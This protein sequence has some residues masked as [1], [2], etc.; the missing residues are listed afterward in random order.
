M[1]I[2]CFGAH[3]DDGEVYAGGTCI[4]WAKAGH[5][6]TLVSMT[7]GDV[8]HYGMAGGELAKRRAAECQVAAKRGGYNS[9]VLDNHD[10]E[11]EP[12]LA[13]RKQ[14][15]RLIRELDAD[16]V[17]SHG[18]MDYHPDHRHTS[19]VVQDAAFMVM[20]PN[21]CPHVPALTKN[22]VFL[23]MLNGLSSTYPL[24]PHIAV[25]V[26]AVMDTKFAALD[27]M[28]SQFYE[29]LPWLDGTLETVPKSMAKRREW[30]AET[31]GPV[32]EAPA[33]QFRTVLAKWYGKT[34]ASKVKHAEIFEIS[35]F[36]HQPAAPEIKRLFPFLPKRRA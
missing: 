19:T 35:P 11:L 6:V 10:G 24:K 8:G 3:P 22:P 20:V 7:N 30:L 27:A 4:Q 36:G 12:S 18:P 14:V 33:R 2:V 13:V 15:I 16:V 23:Y 29:W 34:R 26:D 32:L 1:N 28:E 21:V 5:R 31:W 25:A 17:I 9:I